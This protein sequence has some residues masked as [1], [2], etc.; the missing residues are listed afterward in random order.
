MRMDETS[1]AASGSAKAEAAQPVI[2]IADLSL[3]F[4][5]ADHPGTAL[6]HGDL[7]IN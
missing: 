7:T 5:T 6:S 2:E 1:A 4:Q 3:V